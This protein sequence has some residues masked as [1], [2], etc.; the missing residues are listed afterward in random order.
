M[1]DN[2]CIISLSACTSNPASLT[3]EPLETF[4]S[5]IMANH[6]SYWI[7]RGFCFHAVV[8][9]YSF[10]RKEVSNEMYAVLR[11]SILLGKNFRRRQQ[12]NR[13]VLFRVW[14]RGITHKAQD[15]FKMSTT[16]FKVHLKIKNVYWDI[17][18][19]PRI[20]DHLPK[21]ITDLFQGI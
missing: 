21:L 16:G 19:W 6:L 20:R 5:H 11:F 7:W 3:R 2:V 18:R 10:V 9:L 15:K 13:N 4:H 17:E 14:I 8:R 12:W 1:T